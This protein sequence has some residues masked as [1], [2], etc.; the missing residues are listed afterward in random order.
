ME[1]RLAAAAFE[2]RSQF[3]TVSRQPI[4]RER[5]AARV[6]RRGRCRACRWRV[7][8]DLMIQT[9]GQRRLRHGSLARDQ[10]LRTA[11]IAP[12]AVSLPFEQFQALRG[13]KQPRMLFID[14]EV[15]FGSLGG[16][17][18]CQQKADCKAHAPNSVSQGHTRGACWTRGARLHTLRPVVF[19]YS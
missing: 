5:Q 2:A 16:G 15:F 19:S 7:A 8:C 10:Q 1:G 3:L 6:F 17:Q 4:V 12:T 13:Q 11:A 18:N 14:V 9:I